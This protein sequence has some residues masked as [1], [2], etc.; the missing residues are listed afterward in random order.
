M[1]KKDMSVQKIILSGLFLALGLVLP[2]LTGQIQQF[3]SMLLPMHL[4]VLICGFV[5]GPFWGLVVGF[6]TPVLRSVLFHMPP[7]FPIAITM[8]FE[9]A[10]YGF[11]T[12]L[13]GKLSSKGKYGI[14]MALI[15]SMVAGR[16][17]WGLAASVFYSMAGMPFSLQAF[18]GGAF[19]SAWPGILIQLILVPPVVRAIRKMNI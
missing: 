9:L 2:F 14:L 7:M 6:V 5:C 15:V 18:V 19:L 11:L 12:G 16:V 13:F 4:P 17:I 8:A 1:M 3:G 10:A